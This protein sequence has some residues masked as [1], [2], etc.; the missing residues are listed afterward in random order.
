MN[1]LESIF[2]VNAPKWLELFPYINFTKDI[3]ISSEEEVFLAA[4]K[5][6]EKSNWQFTGLEKKPEEALTE[7]KV[8]YYDNH[9]KVDLKNLNNL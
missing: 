5:F 2:S 4:L 7:Y 9:T 8:F 3:N 1:L 6:Y